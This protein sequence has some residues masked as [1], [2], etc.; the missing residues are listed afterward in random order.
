MATGQ[1]RAGVPSLDAGHL[2]VGVIT[3]R[4]NHKLVER[5][6]DGA[7]RAL[8]ATG[9]RHRTLTAPGAFELP[10]AA[11]SL[12]ASGG[13]DAVV[14]LGV[15]IRGAT[16]H[17]ELVADGCSTGV[18]SVQLTTGVPIGMGVLTVENERQA[19]DRSEPAGGHNV[20]EEATFAAIEMALLA[21]HLG[22]DRHGVSER[23]ADTNIS[24]VR[25]R[26]E[27]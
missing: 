18:M 8:R 26:R 23:P 22:S 24:G 25:A 20:G 3:S 27:S 11:R 12:I 21:E 15:V 9:A 10:F 17:Y 6:A 4:W 7:L 16:T 19:L 1:T 14:V 5:L 2:V 13:V